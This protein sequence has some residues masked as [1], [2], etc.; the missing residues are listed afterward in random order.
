MTSSRRAPPASEEKSMKTGRQW[1]IGLLLIVLLSWPSYGLA[2]APRE[3]SKEDQKAAPKAASAEEKPEIKL[4]EDVGEAA[5][6]E[7][8]KVKQEIQSRAKTL[9][10]RTPLGWDL[11]TVRSLFE[12]AVPLPSKIPD[13]GRHLLSEGRALGVGGSLLVLFFVLLAVYSIR[14]KGRAAS[15]AEKKAQPLG[16]RIPPRLHPY[17]QSFLKVAVFSLVPLFL[18]AVFSILN[19]M[20]DYDA[21]WFQLTGR[22][23]GLWAIGAVLLSVLR[24]ACTQGLFSSAGPNRDALFRYARLVSLYILFGLAALWTVHAFHIRP[25]VLEL[26]RFAVRVYIFT[27]LLLF[28]LKKKAVL[29]FFP[30]LPSRGYRLVLGFLKSYYYLLLILSFAAALL[31]AVG[32]HALGKMVLVKIWFT[33]GAFLAL[34]L[35]CYRIACLLDRWSARLDRADEAAHSL[36]R[37]LGSLLLYAT[38]VF[39]AMIAL[40][41]LGLLDPIQRIM[42]VPIFRIGSTPI[43]V[44]VILQVVLILLAFF[45]ASRLIQAYLDYKVYPALGV[46]PGLG[47]ALNTCIK[48]LFLPVGLLISL[49]LVGIDLSF[50]LVFAGAAGIGIGLG[51]QSVTSSVISGFMIIFGGKIRKGDWIEV[52][53]TLGVVTDI[54]LRATKVLSRA[55]IE[56]I[57]PNSDLVS[58]TIVNYSLSSPLVW[59]S[60]PVGVSYNANPRE[61]ERILLETA[62]KEPLVSK[63]ENPSVFLVGYGDSAINF[64]LNVCIDVR[65]TA[66]GRVRSNLYF[67]IFDAFSKAGIAIPF[68]QRDIHIR[69]TVSQGGVAGDLSLAVGSSGK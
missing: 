21:A 41:L 62:A 34:S 68:P 31:W 17:F 64:E 2:K 67:A 42:S 20:I 55:N 66:Q 48:C 45:F 35:L 49:K 7:V 51:L 15:W 18:L 16:A 5:K 58:K 27:L 26:L 30:D 54:Y 12:E 43:A 10:E 40:N 8:A 59:I 38:S 19:E 36:I 1:W 23:L 32:Y 44:W 13:A 50:L 11:Q 37:S 24:E 52:G 47:Y 63:S 4:T 60:L 3:V 29:S 69:S 65:Y 28:S 39:T 56:Y 53:G 22:L 9:F 46:D 33:L 6:R 25:E 57:I 14:V 61:V